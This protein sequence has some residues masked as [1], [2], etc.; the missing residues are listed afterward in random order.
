[1]SNA[2]VKRNKRLA[3]GR[4]FMDDVPTAAVAIYL[5][6]AAEFELADAILLGLSGG[7]SLLAFIYHITRQIRTSLGS[8]RETHPWG[9]PVGS[10][11]S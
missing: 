2:K 5:L 3:Y 1:M 8:T 11:S 9:A 7:Y 10:T 4:L 6:V